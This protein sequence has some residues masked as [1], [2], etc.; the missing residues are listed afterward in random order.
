M[1]S[2]RS[3]RLLFKRFVP[4]CLKIF[5]VSAIMLL[6]SS[7]FAQTGMSITVSTDSDMYDPGETVTISGVV[8]DISSIPVPAA[9]ISIQVKD[10]TGET[11]FINVQYSSS[12]GN[13][14]DSFVLA[15][16]SLT[17]NYEVFVAASKPGFADC[18]A[19]IS[20]SV[21]RVVINQTSDFAISA[22]PDTQ[23]VTPGESTQ[24]NLSLISIRGF[25]SIVSLASAWIGTAPTDVT[26][27]LSPNP[28]TPLAGQSTTSTLTVTT[29]GTSSTG[30]YTIRVTGS[31]GSLSHY[32]DITLTITGSSDFTISASPSSLKVKATGSNTT[33]VTITSTGGFNSA[34]SLAVSGLPSGVTATFNPTSATPSAGGSAT[35]TLMISANATA[36]VGTHSF[37][38]TGTSG[39]ISHQVS[40]TLEIAKGAQCIIATAT[41]GSELSPEVQFLRGFRDGT[42]M[43][44]FAGREFMK[45][46]NAWYYSFSPYIADSLS[47]QPLLKEAMKILLYPLISILKFAARSDSIFSFNSEIGVIISGFA[48][49]VLIGIVYFSPIAIVLRKIS[50]MCGVHLKVRF[51]EPILLVLLSSMVA[52][53]VS[54]A[55]PYYA[56]MTVAT[57]IFVVA[58]I[59]LSVF[60]FMRFLDSCL[61]FF[62]L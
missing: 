44:T 18:H 14:T 53:S 3:L 17:G 9:M 46:F 13:Y 54:E 49:S 26:V 39:T 35:S 56:T 48:A 55:L 19:Q 4:K 51:E 12:D 28:V 29:Q 58:T 1:V 37:A 22:Y 15:N 23:T 62:R 61:K 43:S 2:S 57:A 60:L 11:I 6:F 38:V 7:A 24:F 41:Y 10:P 16:D 45:A 50:K 47:R 34:V 52:I 21:P 42:V 32:T 31:S 20:F 59:C 30:T 27:S 25:S 40:I 36:P 8:K 5:A 33:T